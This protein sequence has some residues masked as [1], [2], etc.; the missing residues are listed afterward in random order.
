[1]LPARA[2]ALD[3]DTRTVLRD[4]GY[5]LVGGT[6]IAAAF[7]PL[8]GGGARQVFIGSSVGL[9]IGIIAGIYVITH[10]DEPLFSGNSEDPIPGENPSPYRPGK[11]AALEVP[12]LHFR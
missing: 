2:H 9:Y 12:V 11:V 3:S 6:V 5:G 4:S 10:R 7:L 1:M 8:T